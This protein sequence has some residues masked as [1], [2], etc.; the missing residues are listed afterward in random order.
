MLVRRYTIVSQFDNTIDKSVL[1][2]AKRAGERQRPLRKPR[3]QIK[4]VQQIF[5][6]QN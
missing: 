2:N 5:N 4:I 3:E 1:D 6:I